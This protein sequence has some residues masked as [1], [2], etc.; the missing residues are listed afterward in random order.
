MN[1]ASRM[2]STC[3]PGRIQVSEATWNLLVASGA[4]SL[5]SPQQQSGWAI[6]SVEGAGHGGVAGAERGR[7]RAT[8]GVEVKG[9]GVMRTYLWEDCSAA[10]IDSSYQGELA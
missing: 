1:T 4:A 6:G 5:R 8:G 2:E 3:E 7:W 10:P 9:K